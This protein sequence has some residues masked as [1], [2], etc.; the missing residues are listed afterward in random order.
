MSS[1]SQIQTFVTVAQT[2]S[3]AKA[4]R[5]LSLPRSTVSARVRA[6]EVRLN[7]RLLHRTTRH[8]TLTDEGR[9]YLERCEETISKLLE[10]E[11][12]LGHPGELSGTIRVTVPIDMSKQQLA[13]TLTTFAD[14][15]PLIHIE[16]IVTDETLDLGANNIDLALRGGAPGAPGLVARSFGEGQL[17]FYASPQ[18]AQERHLG[19]SLS[20]LSGHVVFDPARKGKG[21]FFTNARRGR[22]ETRN[23]ELAKALAMQSKGIA[24][25][26]DS[27]CKDAV[28]AGQLIRLS[29]DRLLPTL[30]LYIVMPTRMQL[31]ARVRSFVNFLTSNQVM[32]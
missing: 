7:V 3:F 32:S 30:P 20:S 8:V 26:P 5:R 28:S 18:Y 17:A 24:F 6:L 9:Q 14:L 1:L 11:A 12:E 22:I 4:G 16:V 27:I 31:P 23:F 21:T 13:R 29:P 2:G 25:L 15:H 19:A 10:V